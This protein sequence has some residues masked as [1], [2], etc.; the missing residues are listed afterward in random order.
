MKKGR[1]ERDKGREV[2]RKEG[3]MGMEGSETVF[4]EDYCSF[5]L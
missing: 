4:R 2:R 3:R 5:R 1:E